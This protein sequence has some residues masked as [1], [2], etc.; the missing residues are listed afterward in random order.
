MQITSPAFLNGAKI[1]SKFTCEGKDTNPPLDF[2]D[3]PREAKSLCLIMED[4]DV[5]H[6]IRKD[7]RWVHWIL[8]NIPPT[9]RSID[10]GSRPPGVLGKGTGNRTAY[11]GPCP[12]D[13]RHR[14]Y[15]TL[16]ALDT[17]LTLPQGSTKEE[18]EKAMQGHIVA[19]SELMGTYEKLTG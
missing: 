19:K 5:P 11:Q 2:K 16:Y 8:F 4:P 13:R 14:Y 9:L 15:F 18:V 1:P 7:G 3:V 10:E 17:L 6:T 12:P